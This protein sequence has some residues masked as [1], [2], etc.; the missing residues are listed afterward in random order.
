MVHVAC[1]FRR[2]VETKSR[3]HHPDVSKSVAVA[4]QHGDGT[5]LKF[6]RLPDTDETIRGQVFGK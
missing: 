5:A 6:Y 4:L 1:V 3:G 2:M